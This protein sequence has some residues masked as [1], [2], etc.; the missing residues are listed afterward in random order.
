MKS[1]S[2]I[3]ILS[4]ILINFSFSQNGV[5]VNTTGAPADNSA[6]LDV[7]SSSQGLLIPRMTTIQRNNINSSALSLLIFN[8]T[9]NCFE[10]YVN[11]GWYSVSCPATCTPPPAPVA[12]YADNIVSDSFTANWN[13]SPGATTYYFD[14]SADDFNTYVIGYNNLNVGN[15]TSF[16][17]TGLSY[18]VS[19]SYRVRAAIASCTSNNSNVVTVT[20]PSYPH[21]GTQVWMPANMNVGTMI[22]GTNDMSNNGILEKYC[23]DNLETNCD[24]YGGLYQWDEAMEYTSS[25]NCDPCGPTTGKGG[26]QGICPSGYHIPSDP[27]WGRYEYCVENYINPTGTTPLDVFQNNIGENGSTDLKAGPGTKMK[28]PDTYNPPWDGTN[29]SGFTAVDAGGRF[30]Y[31]NIFYK[32]G[33]WGV[34]FYAATEYEYDS[35]FAYVHRLDNGTGQVDRD[36]NYKIHGFSIRCLKD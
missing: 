6:I 36:R 28:V 33:G 2:I 15:T 13:A 23:F 34:H 16:T 10:A 32:G 11:G 8:T 17:V 30:Y 7:S 9:T 5:S 12:T 22:E 27:E 18:D 14:L 35:S 31:G 3:I 4:L 1:L 29:S 21:C 20:I 24:I 19:Y 26:V 25:V